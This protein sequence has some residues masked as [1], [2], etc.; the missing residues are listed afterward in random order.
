[1]SRP[2]VILPSQIAP[3]RSMSL[4]MPSHATPRMR[5]K[6]ATVLCVL[7]SACAAVATSIFCNVPAVWNP[8]APRRADRFYNPQP[9]IAYRL[10]RGDGPVRWTAAW[11][12]TLAALLCIATLRPRDRAMRAPGDRARRALRDRACLLAL[13][14][15]HVVA[16]A[17]LRAGYGAP[18]PALAAL[19]AFIAWY[20]S[21]VSRRRAPRNAP[22]PYVVSPML[23]GL[24]L[25]IGAALV[26]C[27]A[28][29][30]IRG[31]R[32]DHAPAP[33]ALYATEWATLLGAMALVAALVLH[34]GPAASVEG[35][36]FSRMTIVAGALGAAALV[37]G[38]GWYLQPL[39]NFGEAV[40]G[41][42]YYSGQPAARSLGLAHRRY[43]FRTIV[44][45]HPNTDTAAHAEEVRLARRRGIRLIDAIEE[46]FQPEDLLRL[47]RDPS[48]RPVLLHCIEGR[49]RTPAWLAVYRIVEQDCS[50]A[51][52]FAEMER[53]SGRRLKSYTI[54]WVQET[55]ARLSAT[56]AP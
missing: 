49:N 6:S 3:T 16:G 44:Y 18:A 36:G 28:A 54:D 2:D 20:A 27:L 38:T 55:A 12:H 7:L 47:T 8:A 29:E 24:A 13:T 17:S 14:G 30:P 53:I 42:L 23:L 56:V 21:F 34:R 48:A 41:V 32:N 26:Q 35:T 43:G 5:P 50:P 46:D 40:P 1:M 22:F 11:C 9:P 51:E 45:V 31:G 25:T 33:A 4:P 19:V 37:T 39:P 52:A 10:V 15:F